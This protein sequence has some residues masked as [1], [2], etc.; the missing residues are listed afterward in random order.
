[1]AEF[2]RIL[3]ALSQ[4]SHAEAQ[5]WYALVKRFNATSSQYIGSYR[6]H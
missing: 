6:L 3:D 1:M 5:N 2:E 4:I